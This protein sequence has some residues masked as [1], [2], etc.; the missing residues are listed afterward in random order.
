VSFFNTFN[1]N[2]I[3]IYIFL[4]KRFRVSI[5]LDFYEL[6]NLRVFLEVEE[7]IQNSTIFFFSFKQ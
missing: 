7:R 1:I 2:Q 4:V 3:Y 6:N 5:I